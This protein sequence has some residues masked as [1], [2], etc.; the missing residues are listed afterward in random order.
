MIKGKKWE[1]SRH[2][3]NFPA[4]QNYGDTPENIFSLFSEDDNIYIMYIDITTPFNLNSY[5]FGDYLAV[6][7]VA[8]FPIF[9]IVFCW[10][11]YLFKH[12]HPY[13]VYVFCFLFSYSLYCQPL[14]FNGF[15]LQARHLNHFQDKG[16]L[17]RRIQPNTQGLDIIYIAF[18]LH[19]HNL[20]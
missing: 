14:H 6:A 4:G 1:N 8:E 16:R 3:T 13:G 17:Y 11:R 2:Q 5:N 18:D 15:P 9:L 20:W 10:N 12:I 19:E 7:V